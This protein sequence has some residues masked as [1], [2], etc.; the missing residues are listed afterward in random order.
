MIRT[1]CNQRSPR[2]FSYFGARPKDLLHHVNVVVEIV[3]SLEPNEVLCK[4]SFVNSKFIHMQFIFLR[5]LAI[6]KKVVLLSNLL[7]FS[8]HYLSP[9][10]I[11]WE[12]STKRKSYPKQ[13]VL[14]S[15]ESAT[16]FSLIWRMLQICLG[17]RP[18][19]FQ[20]KKSIK[21][22]WRQANNYIEVWQL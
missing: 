3:V 14:W 7:K 12:R 17:S 15:T 2:L 13:E 22:K 16:F 9:R 6:L 8:F 4:P 21:D 10:S 19:T 1:L 18:F 5:C 20:E 11:V